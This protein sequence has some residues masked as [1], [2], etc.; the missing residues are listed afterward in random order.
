MK[1]VS[2]ITCSFC[3]LISLL[4]TT[5]LSKIHVNITNRLQTSNPPL[6]LHCKS[7]DDDLGYHTLAL[8]QFYT[9]AF[10]DNFWD[11]TLF[12]C[13]FWYKG[14]HAGFVVYSRHVRCDGESDTC[15]YEARPDG[16]YLSRSQ[17]AGSWQKVS[18]WNN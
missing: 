12:W 15:Y 7:K 16:F 14:K 8:N 17:E 10:H 6:G 5:C 18:P 4:S 13:N 2:F 3:L 11:T 9:W 1:R